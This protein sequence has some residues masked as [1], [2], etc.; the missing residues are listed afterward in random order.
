MQCSNYSDS[1]EWNV[2]LRST[3]VYMYKLAL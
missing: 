2:I 3:L 1:A